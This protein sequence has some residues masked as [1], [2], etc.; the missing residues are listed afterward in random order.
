MLLSRDTQNPG[1]NIGEFLQVRSCFLKGYGTELRALQATHQEFTRNTEIVDGKAR[2]QAVPNVKSLRYGVEREGDQRL[3]VAPVSSHVQCPLQQFVA[4]AAALMIGRHE[5]LREKPQV[6]ARPAPCEPEDFVGLF[7]DPQP[8]S[9]IFKRKQLKLG[10]MRR[11]HWS[12]AVTVGEVVDVRNDK[13]IASLQV[14]LAG[15]SAQDRH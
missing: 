1:V 10:W 6:A 7:R 8:A 14:L 15:G 13:L 11:G 2:K 9:I 3:L 12:K 4:D 5:E